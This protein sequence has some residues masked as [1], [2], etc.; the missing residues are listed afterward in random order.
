MQFE[1]GKMAAVAEYEDMGNTPVPE[2][3]LMELAHQAS[4]SNNT[5]G[6]PGFCTSETVNDI[7]VCWRFH[8]FP[9]HVL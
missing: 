4:Y 3:I 2:A 6:L 7:T 1:T 8:H 5:L 9:L